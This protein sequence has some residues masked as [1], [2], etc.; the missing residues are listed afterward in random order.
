MSTNIKNHRF[1]D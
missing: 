1:V